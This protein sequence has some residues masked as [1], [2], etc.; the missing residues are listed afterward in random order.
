MN[1]VPLYGYTTFFNPFISR[2]TLG[3]FHS[4]A[5]MNKAAMSTCI[6]VSACMY[7]FLTLEYV[8]GSEIVKS[9]GNSIL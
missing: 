7:V 4:L 8:T 6:Q 9:Y 5:I 2:W 3:C 1:I